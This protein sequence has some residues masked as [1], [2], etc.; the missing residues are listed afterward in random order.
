MFT[1]AIYTHVF[2]LAYHKSK[3]PVFQITN[4]ND[5]PPDQSKA[6]LRTLPHG[7]WYH[8]TVGSQQFSPSGCWSKKKNVW[9]SYKSNSVINIVKYLQYMY[10][11]IYR[12]F[13]LDI[14][15]YIC[16]RRMYQT[17]MLNQHP[18]S[19]R[20]EVL[21][22]HPSSGWTCTGDSHG[23]QQGLEIP[24][25]SHGHQWLWSSAG[26]VCGVQKGP[27][28]H[29]HIHHG[30]LGRSLR[31]LCFQD[32]QVRCGIDTNKGRQSKI[33]KI[34]FFSKVNCAE[35]Q[36]TFLQRCH[37]SL[38]T[39]QTS[40]NILSPTKNISKHPKKKTNQTNPKKITNKSWPQMTWYSPLSQHLTWPCLGRT[41][42]RPADL[43]N[44]TSSAPTTAKAPAMRGQTLRWPRCPKRSNRYEIIVNF[45]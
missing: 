10:V 6:L 9:L 8:W 33:R 40:Q 19:H 27:W 13:S 21:A 36:L 2:A 1:Y 4:P 28:S 12:E 20:P 44:S 35:L 42:L 16:T 22:R 37:I 38:S 18:R 25:A 24:M 31:L 17:P 5:L 29:G 23:S 14:D 34:S 32:Q 3:C 43:T 39:R 30:Y 41:T 15:I 7:N 11:Y 45:T 26:M